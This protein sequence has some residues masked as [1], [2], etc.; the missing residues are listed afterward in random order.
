MNDLLKPDRVV[1]GSKPGQ[2]IDYLVNLY[3]YVQ[4]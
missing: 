3:S 1:I 2:N 4:P